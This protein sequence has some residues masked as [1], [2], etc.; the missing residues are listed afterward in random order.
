MNEERPG[1]SPASPASSASREELD[2]ILAVFRA[3]GWEGASLSRLSAA[4]GLHRAS[5]YHRFPGGKTA[6]AVAAI[7]HAGQKF[8]DDV[9]APLTED[10]D[11]TERVQRT[12]LRLARF[13]GHGTRWCLSD[14]ITLA[15]DEPAIA[16]AVRDVVGGWIE[17]FAAAAAE[18]GHDAPRERA[19]A[20]LVAIQGSLVVARATGD[21]RPFEDAIASLDTT[22]AQP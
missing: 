7:R 4:T 20:A 14:T 11:L 1:S 12:G 19:I 9:L 2:Q 18:A 10:G 13:F 8:A 5:L 21:T 16:A 6:M 3:H 15:V 17:A 22:L